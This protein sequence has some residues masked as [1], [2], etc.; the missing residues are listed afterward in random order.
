MPRRAARLTDLTRDVRAIETAFAV[1]P[2]VVRRYLADGWMNWN[3][4]VTA[5][6]KEYVLRRILAIPADV[7]RSI[8]ALM[9]VLQGRH[10]PVQLPVRSSDGDTVIVTGGRC[11]SL[12]PWADGDH[13][14]G[15]DL[16]LPGV[17]ALGRLAGTIHQALA[18]LPTARG[19]PPPPE[20]LEL[21]VQDAEEAARRIVR[22]ERAVAELCSPDR[23]DV[24]VRAMLRR[25]L[26]LLARWRHL[27]PAEASPAGPFGRVHGD[28]NIRNLLFQGEDVVAVLDWDRMRITPYAEELVKAAVAFCGTAS[29]A[30][31]L[32]RVSAFTAGYRA[33]VPL[34]GDA[35]ADAVTRQWW[36]RATDAWPAEFRYLRVDRSQ[37]IARILAQDERTLHWWTSHLDE[38]T[39]AFTAWSWPERLPAWI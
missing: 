8:L 33:V 30:L 18:E 31:D 10:V 24:T 12:T 27:Q 7:A 15:L 25:R 37:R 17:T 39:A 20:R 23:F 11:Y 5:G 35:I 14:S 36:K 38:V 13:R 21:T 16:S 29:G 2:L 6:D 4:Q 22:V 26:E 28:L 1:G 32:A 34:N 9:P 19:L 3:W